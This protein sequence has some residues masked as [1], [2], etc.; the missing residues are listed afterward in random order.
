[1]TGRLT[2]ARTRSISLMSA[3]IPVSLP[4]TMSPSLRKNSAAQAVQRC[5]EGEGGTVHDPVVLSIVTDRV[6]GGG[7]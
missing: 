2:V 7:P 6:S 4:V 5:R 1:M 3:A